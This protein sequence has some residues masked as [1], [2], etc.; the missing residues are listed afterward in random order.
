MAT[1]SSAF[2]LITSALEADQSAL[3]VV[4]NNVANANT[5]GYTREVPNWQENKP[6][7]I[8]GI[9][10]G[11]GV[12]ETGSTSVRNRVLEERLA[13]Q[14]QAASASSTQLDALKALEALFAPNSSVSGS[15]SGDIGSDIT[16]F[17]NAFSA[18][19]AAPTDNA[20]RQQ[21][22]S[23]A[24]ILAGDVSNAAANLSVQK[25]SLDQ[26]AGAVTDQVNS[27]TAA[28]AQINR[29]IQ[30][31]SP[32]A[33]AGVLEDQRQ[34]DL[35]QLSQLIGFN[36]TATENN[37]VALTTVSGEL[38]VSGSKSFPLTTGS[39]GGETHFFIGTTDVTAQLAVGGA[40]GG[41]LTVRDQDIPTV[42]S[43]L[44]Q[45][46]Y[47]ISTS[48]NSV[49]NSGTDLNGAT[50]TAANPLYIFNEPATV[51]GSAANMSVIMT[52]PSQIAA[53]GA[54]LGTGDNSNACALAAL[55]DQSIV[56][57]SKPSDYYSKFVTKLGSVVAQVQIQSTAQSASLTQ[58]QTQRD[59]LS[60]V[61]LND[62][63]AAMQQIE[64]SYQAASQVFNI[65]NTIMASVLNLGIQSAVS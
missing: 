38:L 13:Q 7:E 6:V 34:Q 32:N 53:S 55:A 45:L 42:M 54:G 48:V 31:N 30:S 19:E 40:L 3:N 16:S 1:I 5:A 39:V 2:N 49:N 4:A 9:A 20:L 61:N 58:L 43:A 24:S 15:T 52:D 29:E 46:A 47:S 56:N 60:G 41:F 8:N 26:E 62:E 21:V 22:L 36:Q 12:T 17:F 51:A 59:S 33:D 25:S 63:A 64:R 18:L 44:D 57:G 27:L 37:G 28:I 50:G 35:K 11:T 14:Q 65:L 10:Y 23:A